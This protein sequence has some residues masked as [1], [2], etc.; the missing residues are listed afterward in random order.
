[1]TNPN[2]G[3]ILASPVAASYLVN[4]RIV[5]NAIP[6]PGYKFLNWS[7]DLTSSASLVALIMN[8][9]KSITANFTPNNTG[10]VSPNS[11]S[12]GRV[13][14]YPNP[15]TDKL[16]Y[17][18]LEK[19]VSKIELADLAGK[20]VYAVNVVQQNG[21]IEISGIQG[22]LYIVKIHTDAGVFIEK[23]MIK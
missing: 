21:S 10:V 15:A 20:T 23:L 19:R 13:D 14:I 7:G 1:L 8:S 12:N 4:A 6:R 2:G 11:T 9:N 22:G 17:N 3:Y 18:S 16:F 5:L